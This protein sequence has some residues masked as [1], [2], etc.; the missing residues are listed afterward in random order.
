[1][2][3]IL[4]AAL[5]FAIAAVTAPVGVSGAVFLMPVQLS[6]L[7]TPSPS[8]TPTNLLYNLMALPGGLLR[9][10]RRGKIQWSLT[11]LL[12]VGTIPGAIAGAIIRVTWL[13][14]PQAFLLVVAA[15]LIPLGVW[16]L[17][18]RSTRQRDG[19][20]VHG[21]HRTLIIALA[22][23]VGVIGGIYGIGGGSLLAPI[24]VGMGFAIGHVASAALASTFVTSVAGL[25]TY[26]VLG[27]KYGSGIAPDW[28]L[29]I[30]LGIGGF[31]GTY[32]GAALQPWLP[33]KLLRRVLGGIG[34]LVGAHYVWPVLA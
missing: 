22:L 24:L 4:A 9:Y 8:V 6:V 19:T 31:A 23:A 28:A 32:A 17:F 12:I 3:L 13:S 33:E 27:L 20:E 26:V 11:R 2:T 25:V 10:K 14:G 5:A 15:V 18:G 21:H 30:A 1:M 29:G 7:H 34:I 16:L